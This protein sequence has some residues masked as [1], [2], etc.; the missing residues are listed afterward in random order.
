VQGGTPTHEWAIVPGGAYLLGGLDVDANPE[1]GEGPLRDVVISPFR[2]AATTVTNQQFAAFVNATGYVTEAE[3]FGS[4]FVFHTLAPARVRKTVRRRLAAAPWWLE[5]KDACWRW[6][7]GRGTH[8]LDRQDHP[9][10]Q[11]SWNDAR[12]YCEWAGVR[13][14]TEAEWEAA[15]RGGR[16]GERYPWGDDLT[17]SARHMCNIWQ[18]SFPNEDAAEDGF[19]GTCPVQSFAPNGYGL[20]EVAGNVWEWCADWFSPA[21]EEGR[22]GRDP[23]GPASGDARVIRGGSFLCHDGY[24]NRYRMAARSANTPDSAASNIGFRVVAADCPKERPA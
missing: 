13:L 23:Q 8:V 2:I 3:R 6:P 22:S 7:G 16:M 21:I 11:V 14:P 1:D 4:S 10:V 18:G 20:Y 5:V 12:A 15:A 19:H 24:C 17:P 9:V